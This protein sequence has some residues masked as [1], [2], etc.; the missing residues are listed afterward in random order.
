MN[1]KKEWK[2]AKER[3]HEIRR[4]MKEKKKQSRYTKQRMGTATKRKEI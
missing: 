1:G 3:T 2:K 4:E